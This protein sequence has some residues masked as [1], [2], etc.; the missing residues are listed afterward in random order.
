MENKLKVVVKSLE[1]KQYYNDKGIVIA[2]DTYNFDCGDVGYIDGY[3]N[4]S[5]PEQE[6]LAIVIFGNIIKSVPLSYLEIIGEDYENDIVVIE[7]IKFRKRDIKFIEEKEKTIKNA[8]FG[9]FV[10]QLTN[11]KTI[12]FGEVIPYER[13][14]GE[15]RCIRERWREKMYKYKKELE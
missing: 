15:I 2:F 1:H 12:W 6:V 3:V 11:D 8:S 14:G 9:G 13:T 7:H 5:T 10:V 4:S